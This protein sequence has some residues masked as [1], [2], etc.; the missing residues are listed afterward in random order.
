[1]S[2]LKGITQNTQGKPLEAYLPETNSQNDLRK[3]VSLPSPI[4][5]ENENIDLRIV[6]ANRERVRLEEL[7]FAGRLKERTLDAAV[8]LSYNTAELVSILGVS[9]YT[10]GLGL[11]SETVRNHQVSQLEKIKYYFEKNCPTGSILSEKGSQGGLFAESLS[12][13]LFNAVKYGFT[14]VT[15]PSTVLINVAIGGLST[16]FEELDRNAFKNGIS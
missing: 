16:T 7:G 5:A 15:Y 9:V 1:M 2:V 10:L 8:N 4:T 12:G 13:T 14:L 6:A 3:N 11:V